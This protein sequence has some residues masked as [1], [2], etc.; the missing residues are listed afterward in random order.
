MTQPRELLQDQQGIT[1]TEY[2]ILLILVA[3]AGF[4]SFQAMGDA[5]EKKIEPTLNVQQSPNVLV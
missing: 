1:T 4:A 3:I 5:V 2:L